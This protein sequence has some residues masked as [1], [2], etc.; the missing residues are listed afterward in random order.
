MTIFFW[1]GTLKL[2]LHAVGCEIHLKS[3]P[4]A[5]RTRYAHHKLQDDE[6]HR[7]LKGH[8]ARRA[9]IRHNIP[10]KGPKEG[11]DMCMLAC[12]VVSNIVW[13]KY[14]YLYRILDSEGGQLRRWRPPFLDQSEASDNAHTVPIAGAHSSNNPSLFKKKKRNCS[15][16]P[17][18]S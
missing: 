4:D 2:L 11:L 3:F 7:I 6:F 16:F 15:L 10:R 9:K 12:T 1:Y 13:E 14:T 17:I 8:R 18:Y 5:S